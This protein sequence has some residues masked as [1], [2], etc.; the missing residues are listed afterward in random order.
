VSAITGSSNSIIIG[1]M[2]NGERI[3]GS[4]PSFGGDFFR[5]SSP[6]ATF[7]WL[8]LVVFSFK[9]DFQLH[10]LLGKDVI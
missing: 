10:S 5:A 1:V 2:V 7:L 3:W 6:Q 9:M 8:F 4:Q